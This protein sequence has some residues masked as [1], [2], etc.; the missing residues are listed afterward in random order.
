[1]ATPFNGGRFGRR[2]PVSHRR[3][4]EVCGAMLARSNYEGG[5][6]CSQ[7]TPG[8]KRPPRLP[9]KSETV[10]RDD[11]SEDEEREEFRDAWMERHE[12][13]WS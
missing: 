3:E 12:R 8:P 4:C 11:E 9:D 10:D 13:E 6:V 1:M 5:D 2:S 7:C